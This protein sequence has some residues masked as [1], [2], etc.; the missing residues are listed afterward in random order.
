MQR[1]SEKHL[2]SPKTLAPKKQLKET[3]K[4]KDKKNS[5]TEEERVA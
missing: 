2:T 1:E 4:E 5:K 3:R